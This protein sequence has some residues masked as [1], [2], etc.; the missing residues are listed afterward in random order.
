MFVLF[1]ATI[2]I[3]PE[4]KLKKTEEHT[5]YDVLKAMRGYIANF[6]TCQECKEHFATM[7]VEI[8]VMADISNQP[9]VIWLWSA[10]NRVR[11]IGYD[12][13]LFS[14]YTCPSDY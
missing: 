8:E 9:A 2:P 14:L 11:F 10:H 3:I 12:Q 7:A 6:F 4:L 5:S 1:V 13:P